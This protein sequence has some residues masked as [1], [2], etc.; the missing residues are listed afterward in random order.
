METREATNLSALI[1]GVLEITAGAQ[2]H[3]W[4]FRGH[5]RSSFQLLPSLYRAIEDVGDALAM[6]GLLLRE[7]DNRSRTVHGAGSTRDWDQAPGGQQ[8]P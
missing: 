8:K 1:D 3:E 4:W 2:E 6:E 7:F 5:G